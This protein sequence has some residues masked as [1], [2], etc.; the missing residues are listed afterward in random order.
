MS[1][2]ICRLMQ[3]SELDEVAQLVKKAGDFAWSPLIIQL[4]FFSPNDNSFVLST[5]NVGAINESA[6]LGYAVIHTVLD[7]SH[8]LNIV[9][10]KQN[11]SKGLGT[12]FLKQLINVVKQK[13]QKSLLLEVRSSNA[14]AI[15]LYEKFGFKRSGIRKAYYPIEKGR[16]D[17]WLYSLSLD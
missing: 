17:A 9:I 4:S 1:D 15:K 5:M 2:Y 10:K 14:K 3:Q 8:L 6:V 7:E 12:N 11:Q 13:N 16:E